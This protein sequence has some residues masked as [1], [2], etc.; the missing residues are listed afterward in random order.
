MLDKSQLDENLVEKMTENFL[1]PLSDIMTNYFKL[2]TVCI[3]VGQHPHTFSVQCGQ[4]LYKV[5]FFVSQ[6]ILFDWFFED[7]FTKIYVH[8]SS[9][10]WNI[11]IINMQLQKNLTQ[12]CSS[13]DLVQWSLKWTDKWQIIYCLE[14]LITYGSAPVCPLLPHR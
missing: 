2:S 7:T 4:N 9:N 11:M 6:A 5:A 13:I 10:L 14:R 12:L 3:S 1:F 8:I